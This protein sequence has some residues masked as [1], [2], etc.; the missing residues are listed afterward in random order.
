MRIIIFLAVVVLA[1][2][3]LY[4]L[5]PYEIKQICFGDVCPDNGGFYVLFK[6][7]YS[8]AECLERGDNPVVG[9]GWGRVY[10]GCS[11]ENIL[12]DLFNRFKLRFS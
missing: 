2:Y 12:G 11:P 9:V 6:Q 8:E 5:S 10:A 3:G 4:T 7:N 1:G